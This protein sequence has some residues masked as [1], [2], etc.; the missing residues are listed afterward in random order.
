MSSVQ[1]GVAQIPSTQTLEKHVVFVR[2]RNEYD[3]LGVRTTFAIDAG[4]ELQH[5]SVC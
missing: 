3:V 5:R 4:F 1:V 2:R